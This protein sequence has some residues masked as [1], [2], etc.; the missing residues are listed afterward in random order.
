MRNGL[1]LKEIYPIHDLNK[2]TERE[3]GELRYGKL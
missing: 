2:V 1:R 3:K